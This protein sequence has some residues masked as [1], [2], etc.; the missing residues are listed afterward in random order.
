LDTSI[1]NVVYKGNGSGATAN[2]Y[3]DYFI[4]ISNCE[5]TNITGCGSTGVN[6]NPFYF[7]ASAGRIN[8]S[9]CGFREFCTG[10]VATSTEFAAIRNDGGMA[11]VTGC[12]FDIAGAETGPYAAYTS[13]ASLLNF[14]GNTYRYPNATVINSGS[15]TATG[16]YKTQSSGTVTLSNVGV[17][18]SS[19]LNTTV[20]NAKQNYLS[21]G[22]VS[23]AGSS[24]TTL[25]TLATLAENQTYLIS[26]RQSGSGGNSVMAYV[27]AFNSSVGAVRMAQSNATGG[28]LDMNVTTSG[29]AIQLVLGSGFGSTTWDWVL[30]RLG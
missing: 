20:N 28:A 25:T 29:N 22:Q 23:A 27:A 6:K 26:V 2:R 13:S 9:G 11:T 5:N 19:I 3:T 15:G 16:I 21:R 4:K 12:T 7:V 10:G 30:T 8:V 18:G 14:V 24:T 17:A 1:S